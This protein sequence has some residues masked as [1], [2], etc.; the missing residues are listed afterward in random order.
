MSELHERERKLDDGNKKSTIWGTLWKVAEKV[1]EGFI[2]KT[3]YNYDEN[4]GRDENVENRKNDATNQPEE[5]IEN[6]LD[7][8]SNIGDDNFKHREELLSHEKISSKTSTSAQNENDDQL[9]FESKMSELDQI[10][11]NNDIRKAIVQEERYFQLRQKA[12]YHEKLKKLAD[13]NKSSLWSYVCKVAQGAKELLIEKTSVHLDFSAGCDEYVENQEN[14]SNNQPEEEIENITDSLRKIEN[15]SVKHQE[16]LFR[17][18]TTIENEIFYE[19]GT[20]KQIY[21]EVNNSQHKEN[22]PIIDLGIQ[23]KA[24]NILIDKVKFNKFNIKMFF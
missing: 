18:T 21:D 8:L 9:L 15:E 7:R 17:T 2:E 14:A 6:V 24:G 13:K 11:T 1:K 16:K 19:Q 10:T 22:V 12:E 3:R 23:G 20:S 5:E 4:D